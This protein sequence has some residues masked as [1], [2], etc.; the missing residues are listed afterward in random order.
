MSE[1]LFYRFSSKL[2]AIAKRLQNALIDRLHLQI[3][4]S[5]KFA[6]DRSCTIWDNWSSRVPWKNKERRK[7]SNRT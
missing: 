1:G 5:W 4:Q 6:N 2:V 7:N 3:C